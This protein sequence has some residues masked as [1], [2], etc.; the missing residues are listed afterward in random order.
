MFDFISKKLSSIVSE[1]TRAKKLTIAHVE[2]WLGRVQSALLEADVSLDV[3]RSFTESIRQE[4]LGKKIDSVL[5]PGEQLVKI[6]HDKIVQFMGGNSDPVVFD[7]QE[8]ILLVGLQGA[9]KTTTIAKLAHYIKKNAQKGGRKPSILAASVDFSRPAAQAQ[10]ECLAQQNDFSFYKP[11]SLNVIDAVD[12]VMAYRTQQA[13]DYL[14]LD[15]AG[16]LQVDDRLMKELVQIKQTLKPSRT[17]FVVDGMTGQEGL[18]A[19]RTFRD[20]VAF[21]GAIITKMDSD[22]RG[23]IAFSFSYV[24]ERHVLFLAEGEKSTQLIP[25]N[26]QRMADRI[27]GMGD[28]ATLAEQAHEKIKKADFDDVSRAFERG[29]FTLRDFSKQL[30]MMDQLGSLTQL[31][32]FL[33]SSLI[34]SV[35]LDRLQQG[36]RDMK[37]FKAIFSSLSHQELDGV[38]KITSHRKKEIAA[39]AG[40]TVADVGQLFERFEQAQQYAKLFKSGGF[41][42]NFR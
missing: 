22:A 32:K 16:R 10:L 14:F 20:H 27:L 17:I 37:K 30:S 8:T 4:A 24:L 1:L 15:T 31:V 12:E 42:K 18:S 38:R 13:F 9:G 29:A 33:P 3:V 39:G 28:I 23:G 25:F 21:D 41:M 34:G 2:E 5:K 6:V 35:P 11:T 26:P 36:E 40:V 19:A 7:K